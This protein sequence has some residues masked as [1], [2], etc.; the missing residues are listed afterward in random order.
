MRK[1]QI[2][3]ITELRARSTHTHT[4]R[5]LAL[6][7]CVVSSAPRPPNTRAHRRGPGRCAPDVV[8]VG[9]EDDEEVGLHEADLREDGA[10][11]A[12]R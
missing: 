7:V 1:V 8:E 10:A 9:D 12:Q 3:L 6:R 2:S 5:E 4:A 11:A